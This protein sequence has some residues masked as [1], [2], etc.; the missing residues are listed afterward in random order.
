MSTTNQA[1]NERVIYTG[2]KRMTN[3]RTVVANAFRHWQK[4]LASSPFDIVEVVSALESFLGLDTNEKKRLMIA[5]H[6]A[7]SKLLDELDAVPGYLIGGATDIAVPTE[8]GD[9]DKIVKQQPPMIIA[10]SEFLIEFSKQFSRA[11]PSDVRD[12]ASA[13]RNEI[14]IS[15]GTFEQALGTFAGAHFSEIDVPLDVSL[16]DCKEAVNAMYNLASE[17]IGPMEVDR[18]QFKTIENLLNMEF[19]T[20][21]DPRE[22]I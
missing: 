4:T 9:D 6:S 12:F 11:S 19:A 17:F 20:R 13:C 5:M 18:V 1:F 3:D 14:R 7:S 15:H 10:I 2:L 16:S 22:L 8:Q 21:F